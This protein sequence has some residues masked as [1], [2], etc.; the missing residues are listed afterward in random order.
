MNISLLKHEFAVMSKSKKNVLFIISLTVLLF[1][2]CLLILPNTETPDSFDPKTLS[3][4]LEELAATQ[5][6]RE[7][8]GATGIILMTGQPHYAMNDFYYNIHKKMITAY[9][10]NDFKRFISLRTHY[11][12]RDMNNFFNEQIQ[13]ITQSPFPIKDVTHL[14]NQ[15]L[16]RYQGYLNADFPLTYAVVEQKTALQTIHNFLLGPAIFLIMFCAIYFS[17]D[18]LVR[19]KYNQTVLQGMPISWYRMLN[20]K[21]IVA[22]F[23]TLVVLSLLLI[24]GIFILS[25]QFGIGSLEI[26]VPIKVENWDFTLDEYEVTTI[27]SFFLNSIIFIPILV[28]L[29]IRLN[30]LLSLFFKNQWLVLMVSTI[31]L[32]SEFIYYTRSTREL[33][34][35]EISNLPQTYFQFGKVV[36][37]EKNFLVNLETITDSKGILV[38]LLTIIAIEIV[39]FAVSRIINKRRFFSK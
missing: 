11:Y 20:G 26:P 31:L 5:E 6:A 15:T 35:I 8:R 34:G 10:D 4:D 25:I 23:Y 9:E 7:A 28:Y 29:F 27:A 22:F 33:F 2:Y 13:N 24:L 16:L 21:T 14:Y 30:I 32:F 39:L 37:G 19:D 38:L 12:E 36:T 3:I 18:V 17:C 1:C